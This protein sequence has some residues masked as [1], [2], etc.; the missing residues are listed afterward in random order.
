MV[1]VSPKDTS[2]LILECQKCGHREYAEV[3]VP[4]GWL[5]EAVDIPDT[6]KT[7]RK[8]GFLDSTAVPVSAGSPD[9]ESTGI[10]FGWI[11]LWIIVIALVV[12]VLWILL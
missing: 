11:F 3:Q 5:P 7:E 4:P 6:K 1:S 8:F 10:P 9:E 2:P 12:L